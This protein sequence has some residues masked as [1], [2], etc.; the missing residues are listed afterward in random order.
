[1][2]LHKLADDLWIKAAPQSF[3]G[4]QLGTRM[5]VVRL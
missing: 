1:M 2:T 4:L 3:F 5:T